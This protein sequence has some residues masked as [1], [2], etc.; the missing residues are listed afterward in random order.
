MQ[1]LRI[2]YFVT[3]Y[4]GTIAF[5]LIAGHLFSSTAEAAD[6]PNCQLLPNG[7]SAAG[8][9]DFQIINS[10]LVEGDSAPVTRKPDGSVVFEPIFNCRPH[11]YRFTILRSGTSEAV[12]REETD[13]VDDDI[14]QAT[15]WAT[16]D[17]LGIEYLDELRAEPFQITGGFP[18]FSV[19]DPDNQELHQYK[20]DFDNGSGGDFE[21][22]P[23]HGTLWFTGD[24]P[25]L[26]P[27]LRYDMLVE[28]FDQR[29]GGATPDPTP[30]LAFT[31]PFEGYQD[32]GIF[33]EIRRRLNPMY[34]IERLNGAA[35]LGGTRGACSVWNN[36][37]SVESDVCLAMKETDVASGVGA[38]ESPT[39]NYLRPA[40]YH[41]LQQRT[42]LVS[43]GLDGRLQVGAPLHQAPPLAPKLVRVEIP[44]YPLSA[45]G[46]CWTTPHP[47]PMHIVFDKPVQTLR[48][49]DPS[50]VVRE[51]AI[52]FYLTP[53]DTTTPLY[54]KMETAPLSNA[55][56]FV[57]F[58]Y[59][60]PHF[61]APT[62]S[63][64][65][66]GEGIW[67]P[68]QPVVAREEFPD[69][70][71]NY[72]HDLD[73]TMELIVGTA[74]DPTALPGDPGYNAATLVLPAVPYASG[75]EMSN[76]TTRGG[77]GCVHGTR[78]PGGD[79]P[80]NFTGI[81]TGTPARLTYERAWVVAGWTTMLNLVYAILVI[82]VAW[83]GLT[84]IAQQHLGGSQS[85]GIR[86]M[87]PR[88]ILGVIAA[89][90]SYWWC[91]LL[92]DLADAV[93]GYISA[94]L[95]VQ[96]G[97][98]LYAAFSTLGVLGLAGGAAGVG[99]F[100][101]GG[102]GA[103]TSVATG[104]AAAV[105][106]AP[107]LGALAVGVMVIVVLL[108]LV[109]LGFGVL[110]LMQMIIRLVFINLLIVL[111]PLAMA[112][113]ILPHTAAWGRSW[114][115][116]W[117]IQLWQHS[118]QLVG[119][120]LAISYIR[121]ISDLGG[122]ELAG[123]S[124][125]IWL[126]ILSIA[127]LYLTYK[128]PSLLGDQGVGEGFLDSVFKATATA[129]MVPRAVGNVAPVAAG[130]AVGGPAGGG[131]AIGRMIVGQQA[132][133]SLGNTFSKDWSKPP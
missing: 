90:T 109:Y 114:L 40:D 68:P 80:R 124:A 32:S 111:A 34:W 22:G 101:A 15:S 133:T 57:V 7:T 107:V 83:T 99:G 123:S 42:A 118:L 16:G 129:A 58:N 70:T 2:L 23:A 98:V 21:F 122:D 17:S 87:V 73:V 60:L 91:R 24:P 96:P 97:D 35:A 131:L 62:F 112:I 119:F 121:A 6:P 51:P 94:A 79:N 130:F 82:I 72:N 20:W 92:I 37:A 63:N 18:A 81:V 12:L 5:A 77:R 10:H 31:I 9:S 106:A 50:D 61:D 100:A 86:E 127:A 126:L 54:A 11:A 53:S 105:G 85:P 59:L 116:M 56:R 30:V 67:F 28:I 55:Q 3:V 93:S 125:I 65:D 76:T 1:L 78:L 89:A 13:G 44:H 48:L 43:R 104:G 128:L 26:H 47:I 29:P 45:Q 4:F 113:W 115:R 14:V 88:I 41:A 74:F 8:Y 69:G 120:S 39:S 52:L 46:T 84:I 25:S 95:H 102:V 19:V 110:I 49:R 66:A 75:I 103:I 132:I 108:L 117:M 64:K 71:V 33:T 27:D 38:P 36:G